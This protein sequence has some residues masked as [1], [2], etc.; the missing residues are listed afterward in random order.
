M[1]HAPTSPLW[2]P[3]FD[4]AAWASG[5]VVGWRV[6]RWR[7]RETHTPLSTRAGA[8]YFVAPLNVALPSILTPVCAV[9]V[10]AGA[11]LIAASNRY[12]S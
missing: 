10:I 6:Y 7:L 12:G 3:V 9:L 5:A 2:H 4:V 1:I 8:G 11:G